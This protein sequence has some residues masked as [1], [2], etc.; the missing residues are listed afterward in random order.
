MTRAVSMSASLESKSESPSSTTSSAKTAATTV[1]SKSKYFMLLCLCV[2]ILRKN[3]KMLEVT[4]TN[5]MI[6][7]GNVFY[8]LVYLVNDMTA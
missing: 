2:I 4:L 1:A 6:F 5:N 7:K 8:R 3:L